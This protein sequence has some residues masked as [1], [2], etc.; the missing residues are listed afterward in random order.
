MSIKGQVLETLFKLDPKVVG[1]ETIEEAK[2]FFQY[3]LPESKNYFFNTNTI[4]KLESDDTIYF[5]LTGQIIAKAIFNGDIIEVDDR[6]KY[7]VGHKLKNVEIINSNRKLNS[8]I[9]KGRAI[10]YLDTPEKIYEIKRILQENLDI[11]P[12]EV[13]NKFSEGAKTKVFVNKYERNPQA[14]RACL[15]HY[16]YNCQ[17]CNFNFEYVYGSIG[18]DCIHVHHIVPLSEINE[19]SYEVD[20]IKDLIPVCPN[21]HLILHKFNAPSIDE[22]KKKFIK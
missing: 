17:I 2:S 13:D 21:C 8:E 5:A 22:L 15:E 11:F 20:P 1:F 6:G 9:I 3:E 19:K 18:K 10:N 14:R 12:D 16:G 7:K 4:S